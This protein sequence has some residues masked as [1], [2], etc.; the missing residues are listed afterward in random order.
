M[1]STDT[2]VARAG[3]LGLLTVEGLIGYE[4]LMSGLTKIFRG[5]FTG[6]LADELSAKSEGAASW[7]SSFLDSV[8][9]P[10]GS[11]FGVVIIAAELRGRCRAHRRRFAMGVP[12]AEAGRRRSHRCPGCYSHSRIWR[13]SHEPQLP[14]RE[15][16]GASLVDPR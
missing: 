10:N 16:L 9:I 6:G 4:W 5:G 13:H 14:S 15:R 7:Y 3:L 12:L 11:F 2:Y 1:D 8:V